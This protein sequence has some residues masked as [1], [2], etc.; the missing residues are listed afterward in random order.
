MR[1]AWPNTRKFLKQLKDSAKWKRIDLGNSGT[2]ILPKSSKIVGDFDKDLKAALKSNP[3]AVFIPFGKRCACAFCVDN[4]AQCRH[5]LCEARLTMG[6]NSSRLYNDFYFHKKKLFSG[7][8]LEELRMD[9]NAPIPKPD[10]DAEDDVG[11][12]DG[13]DDSLEVDKAAAGMGKAD[14]KS[15]V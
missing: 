10:D 4:D 13:N 11:N 12:G 6:M 2:V 8:K 15:V 9:I 7:R 1:L 14:R 5:E 3:R